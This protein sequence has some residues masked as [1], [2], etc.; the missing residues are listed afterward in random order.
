[1]RNHPLKDVLELPG[2][3]FQRPVAAVRPDAP[4]SEVRLQRMKHLGAITVLADGKAWPHLPPREKRRTRGDGDGEA[5]FAVDVSR[6]VRREELATVPRGRRLIA[7]LD[8]CPSSGQ[9]MCD[10]TS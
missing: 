4:A 1:M 5:A 7:H 10:L 9:R 2:L 6:D 3:P 8:Y